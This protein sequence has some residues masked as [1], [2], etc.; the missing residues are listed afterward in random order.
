MLP[1]NLHAAVAN[2]QLSRLE[3]LQSKR[4]KIWQIYDDLLS[5]VAEISLPCLQQ[6]DSTHG[7]FT[8]CIKAHNRDALAKYLLENGVY[9]TLRYHPL[10]LTTLFD[11]QGPALR[12]TEQLNQEALSLP[13]HPR[14]TIDD[15]E[16]VCSLIID[17]YRIYG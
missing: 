12:N 11:H 9:T 15:A 3:S 8:Y 2:V 6:D 13:L 7:L 1:T 16:K 14:M 5:S 4:Y 17:F 10:H